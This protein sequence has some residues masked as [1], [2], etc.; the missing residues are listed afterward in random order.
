MKKT[1][2]YC[3]SLLVVTNVLAQNTYQPITAKNVNGF[4]PK[5]WKLI[6]KSFGD[7]NKDGNA[8]L[9]LIIEKTDENNL[10]NNDNLGSDTL[11]INPRRLIVAFAKNNGYRLI[12]QNDHLVPTENA[13]DS[14]CLAD[15][16]YE[17][18]NKGLSIAKGLLFLNFKYWY[19]CGTW[20]V[21]TDTYTFRWQHNKF[22]L[23]GFDSWE[24]H[25]ASHDETKYSINYSTG[26]IETTKGGNMS[27]D[28][29]NH[30]KT[31]R[32]KLKKN[33]RYN[34]ATI[35]GDTY[36]IESY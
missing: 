4:I 13:E 1:L 34:L 19:S 25:R 10:I 3:F 9:A 31:T 29:R 35:S 27:S 7:L 20:F 36:L 15:P 18:E 8:D 28:E 17:M 32:K 30:P 11:N 33:V 2:L 6:A 26:I 23:I 24:F 16:L 21:N 22:E 12:V 5:G 14:P